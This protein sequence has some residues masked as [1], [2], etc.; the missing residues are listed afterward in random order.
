MW[1]LV[2]VAPLQRVPFESLITQTRRLLTLRYLSHLGIALNF[3]FEIG[4]GQ[5]LLYQDADENIINHL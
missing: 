5:Q 3:I 1:S 4:L 2:R